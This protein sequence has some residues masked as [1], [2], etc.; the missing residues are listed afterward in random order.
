MARPKKV[1][2][3]KSKTRYQPIYGCARKLTV[4]RMRKGRVQKVKG[5]KHKACVK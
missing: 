2:R 5:F 4:Y 3:S 1:G